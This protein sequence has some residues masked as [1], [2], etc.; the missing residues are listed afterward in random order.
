[1]SK[2]SRKFRP[3]GYQCK[4]DG[5][6]RIFSTPSKLG[7]HIVAEH[8]S[9][10]VAE[11]VVRERT[12]WQKNGRACPWGCDQRFYSPHTLAKHIMGAH[13]SQV[14]AAV[15]RMKEGGS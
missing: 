13:K 15:A 12:D 8:R 9:P 10:E 2:K 6:G 5:C 11:W 7:Y 4:V 14:D 1:M 3:E